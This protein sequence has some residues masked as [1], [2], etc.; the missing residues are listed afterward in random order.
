MNRTCI[1]Y[2]RHVPVGILLMLLRFLGSVIGY[3]AFS[4]VSKRLLQRELIPAEGACLMASFILL[5]ILQSGLFLSSLGRS[6]K[7]I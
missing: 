2:L 1:R 5:L 6:R 7:E 4:E 3:H